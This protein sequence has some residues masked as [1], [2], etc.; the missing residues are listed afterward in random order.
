MRIPRYGEMEWST[1]KLNEKTKTPKI[2]L[3]PEL[4]E[5]GKIKYG[6]KYKGDWKNGVPHGE[7]ESNWAAEL[8]VQLCRLFF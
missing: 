1:L 3:E 6:D 8:A 5:H 4:D 7:G 2:P